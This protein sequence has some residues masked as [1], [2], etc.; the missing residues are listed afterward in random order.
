MQERTSAKYLTLKKALI[1]KLLSEKYT[2]GQKLPTENELSEYYKVSRTTIRSTLSLLEE[3]GVVTKKKGSGSF[4]RGI[5]REPEKPLQK[6]DSGLLG[7]WNYSFSEYIYTDIVAGIEETLSERGYSLAIANSRNKAEISPY[8]INRLLEQ[9]IKGLFFEPNR[10]LF[11]NENQEINRLLNNLNIPIVTTHCGI[12]NVKVSTVSVDDV[13][14]GYEAIRYLLDRGHRDICYIYPNYTQA[15]Y[16]RKLGISK[17]FREFGI[18]DDENRFFNY[19]AEEFIDTGQIGF[20]MTKKILQE[21]NRPTAVFF[22]N[23]QI[24]MQG[25]MAIYELGLK[26]PDDISVISIDNYNT[27]EILFPPLTTFEHPKYQLGYWAAK[28]M[29]DKLENPSNT[30]PMKIN[31]EPQLI[32]R[33]SVRNI[34]P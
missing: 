14:A 6:A 18:P 33:K 20:H 8:D 15:A 23:D 9:D 3:E 11:L 24:A 1:E 30:L 25:Y 17:A 28:I 21:K 29:I 34:N 13:E 12:D 10:T 27:S 4:F 2:P 26:I 16:D 5:E 32:E 22:F 31:F 7:M 19:S